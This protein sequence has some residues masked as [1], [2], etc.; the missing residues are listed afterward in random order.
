[1][2]HPTAQ[3]KLGRKPKWPV[4]VAHQLGA[5][6]P[7]YAAE[8]VDGETIGWGRAVADWPMCLNDKIGC[9][10][11]A[12]VAH[13]AQALGVIGGQERIMS[14]A[15][16]V[17]NYSLFGYHPGDPATDRGAAEED[18]LTA[19]MKAGMA[20]GGT[21]DK[22]NGFASIN[23]NQTG[24]A[25]FALAEFGVVYVGVN[26]PIAAQSHGVWD[27]P[28]T[29]S[30]IDQPGSWGGHCM[31]LIEAEPDEHLDNLVTFVTW[32]TLQKATW[33]WWRT[34]CDEAHAVDHPAWTRPGSLSG[35]N[36][37]EMR[38]AMKQIG[39]IV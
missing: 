38:D 16:V 7:T 36:P 3:R 31:L 21:L 1:M 37:E 10:T 23:P 14:D 11:V 30:P 27:V 22:I 17:Q 26:L 29:L 33:R 5:L 6:A 9:C 2:M 35:F 8:L 39:G 15:E 18:V 4:S 13:A 12:G 24:I 20:I 32:G 25:R 28:A 34:Y 19:W